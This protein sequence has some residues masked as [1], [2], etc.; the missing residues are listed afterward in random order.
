[1][2]LVD[3]TGEQVF[4]TEGIAVGQIAIGRSLQKC[5]DVK[6]QKSP[7]IA[8]EPIFYMEDHQCTYT[9]MEPKQRLHNH[10]RNHA[11]QSLQQQIFTS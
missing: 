2:A 11:I 4:T 1:M 5:R 9:M 6:Y 10:Y 8:F 7:K 3:P